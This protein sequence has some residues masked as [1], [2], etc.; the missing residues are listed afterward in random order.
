MEMKIIIT[1][2][3]LYK[4]EAGGFTISNSRIEIIL[5]GEFS[6]SSKRSKGQLS[7]FEFNYD[8][9]SA[10]KLMNGMKTVQPTRILR[11]Q[12]KITYGRS[13]NLIMMGL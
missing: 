1:K 8:P 7:L 5:N 3:G 4:N 10:Y 11:Y 9:S 12:V 6:Y 13:M 2:I